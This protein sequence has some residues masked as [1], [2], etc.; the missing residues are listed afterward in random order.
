S[1]KRI[2]NFNPTDT[3]FGKNPANLPALEVPSF[4]TNPQYLAGVISQI[5]EAL[6]RLTEEQK[7]VM[8]MMANWKAKI[9]EN[10]TLDHFNKLIEETQKADGK[11][12]DNVKRLL[13]S[14]AIECGFMFDK[15]EKQFKEKVA[16]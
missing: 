9:E 3:A 14:T 16:A 4:D 8:E 12:R 15:K 5:K 1:G 10:N 11:V 7:Q 13:V 2:L 6:N